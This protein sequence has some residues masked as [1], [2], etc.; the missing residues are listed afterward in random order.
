MKLD[1][2]GN[3]TVSSAVTAASF[4][5]TFSGAGAMLWQ[6]VSGTTQQAQPNTG[7][8]LTNNALVTVT[9]PIAPNLGDVVRVSGVGAGG[10]KIAQNTNQFVSSGNPVGNIGV[11]W[12]PRD[13][14]R[15]WKSVASSYDGTKLVAVVSNGQ[16][17]TSVL[18]SV[19]ST[20]SSAAGYLLGSQNCAIELQY[21]GNGQ[22]IPISHE[23]IILVF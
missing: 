8:L 14:T 1:G 17:Y 7:Y 10:W 2:S 22:F 11:T 3:L 6:V 21:L 20:T 23:G 13:S 9:L 4:S 12:T 19:S 15:N 16:I 5:G 18:S